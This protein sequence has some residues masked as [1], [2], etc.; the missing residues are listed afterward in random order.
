[1]KR[2]S[3]WIQARQDYANARWFLLTV[4][5]GFFLGLN[6][7]AYTQLGG[8][9]Y[10]KYLVA[11]VFVCALVYFI[12]LHSLQE[13]RILSDE[14]N[15]YIEKHILWRF[16]YRRCVEYSHEDSMYLDIPYSE[17][18]IL[19]DFSRDRGGVL[20]LC[21][22]EGK[23]HKIFTNLN[24]LSECKKVMQYLELETGIR[25]KQIL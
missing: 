14:S 15:I 17:P 7:D 13:I 22:K 8:E 19:T 20:Y 16:Y 23:K 21:T 9:I 10:I 24:D 6:Y 2:T 25:S 11:I 3:Q 5:I 4:C 18:G 1:M 12:L